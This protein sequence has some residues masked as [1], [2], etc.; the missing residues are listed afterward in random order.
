MKTKGILLIL[1]TAVISGF[2]IFINKF[3]VSVV[4]PYVFTGLKNVLVAVFVCCLLLAMK[5]WK[6]LRKM[7]RKYWGLLLAIGLVGGSVP[8]L[9]FFKGLSMTTGVQG[10]FIHKTMFL[11]VMVLAAVFLKEKI[12][13]KLLL[14]GLFLLLSNAFLLRIIPHSLGMGDLLILLATLLWAV[15]NTISKHTLKEL[16][17]RIVVWGRMFFG[18]FFILIFLIVTSQISLISSLG[19]QQISWVIVTSIML[20]GYVMT[21]YSGLRYVPVSVAAPLL[22]L[23]API[24]TLLTFIY[25]GIIAWSQILGL[26]LALGGVGIIILCLRQLN[27]K[28]DLKKGIKY[29]EETYIRA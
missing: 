17:A 27:L 18:S 28:H 11:Y 5:D 22:L 3:G 26:S 7:S 6:L 9:L 21:W 1:S 20:F 29:G 8:F 15:E 23:G 13:K 12:S 25:T 10:A 14:G 2:S 24:T 16:P 4:N 19:F